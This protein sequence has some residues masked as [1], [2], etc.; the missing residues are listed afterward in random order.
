MW[1]SIEEIAECGSTNDLL[2]ERADQGAPA[3]TVIVADTQTHGRGRLGRTWESVPGENLYM[4][5]LLRPGLPVAQV[6]P[7]TLAA[8]IAVAE[9]V[10]E[11]GAHAELKWPND[12]LVADRKVAGILTEMG[13]AGDDAYVVIGIGANLN[14]GE[15]SDEIR[16]IATSVVRCTS[17]AVDRAKFRARLL[18][19]LQ[20]WLELFV[21][22]GVVAI[23]DAWTDLARLGRVSVGDTV[24]V[25]RGLAADGALLVIGDDGVEH[26]IH[27]GDV[28]L[29][30]GSP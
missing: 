6:P 26:T 19:R 30:G 24:G 21:L 18:H 16:D 5:C 1:T 14:Q 15:F 13:E 3:G 8:G 17:V 2:K 29:E 7:I 25:A 28:V 27:S 22:G 20:Y 4:S 10:R 9:T 23:A 12:V 11:W